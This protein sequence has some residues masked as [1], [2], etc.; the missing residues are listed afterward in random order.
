MCNPPISLIG[1]IV[2]S[3]KHCLATSEEAIATRFSSSLPALF[4]CPAV[5]NTQHEWDGD[6]WDQHLSLL[7][8]THVDGFKC[9][10]DT[11]YCIV[12]Q[13]QFSDVI[14]LRQC[15]GVQNRSNMLL[16]PWFATVTVHLKCTTGDPVKTTAGLGLTDR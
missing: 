5:L 13:Q 15:L 6:R 9:N 2:A 8:C 1:A 4:P 3:T 16:L 14:F 11:V 10:H 7:P 12:M